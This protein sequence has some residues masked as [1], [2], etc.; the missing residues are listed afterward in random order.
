LDYLELVRKRRSIRRYSPAPLSKDA[1]ETVLEAARLAPSSGNTQC[2]RYVVVTDRD[3]K[4]KL[5]EAGEAFV[6][7]APA[8]IVACADPAT[9]HRRAGLDYFLVD[10]GISFEHLILAATGLGLGTCWIGGFDE[11]T[12]KKILGVPDE[13]RVVAYTPL[14]YPD[15]KKGR[16]FARKPL[17]D[18]CF[19]EKYGQTNSQVIPGA[20]LTLTESIYIKSRKLAE[21]LKNNLVLRKAF[22]Y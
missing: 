10:I 16:V 20:F 15:E 21:K 5:A 18:I 19:Y 7:E 12:V 9:S 8:I 17:R 22:R 3:I 6:E 2:W 13:I 4:R 11:E 1:L 14:G